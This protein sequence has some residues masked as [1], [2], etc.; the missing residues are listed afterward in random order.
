M[1][2]KSRVVVLGLT[3]LILSAVFVSHRH[4][5]DLVV[6]DAAPWS[7]PVASPGPS[8]PV[9][10][11][12]GDRKPVEPSI[13]APRT[14]LAP[15][16]VR[17]VDTQSR[18]VASAQVF[19]A[20][21][22]EE[23]ALGVSDAHG[24]LR[25]ENTVGTEIGDWLLAR[26]SG[27]GVGASCFDGSNNHT[28]VIRLGESVQL[29][30]RILQ[31]IEDLEGCASITV[32][33]IPRYLL[34]ATPKAGWP[35]LLRDSRVLLTTVAS[36]SSFVLDGAT[37]GTVYSLAAGGS[38]WI[39]DG[40]RIETPAPAN[41]IELDLHQL[42]ATRLIFERVDSAPF[43]PVIVAGQGWG[44]S[45]SL[46]APESSWCVADCVGLALAGISETELLEPSFEELLLATSMT[47]NTTHIAADASV[48]WLGYRAIES[49][50]ELTPVRTGLGTT[51]LRIEPLANEWGWIA[52]DLTASANSSTFVGGPGTLILRSSEDELIRLPVWDTTD[53][54]TRIGPIPTGSYA[55]GFE[56]RPSASEFPTTLDDHFSIQGD[57]DVTIRP[58]CAG[59][60]SLTI[61]VKDS[62][63]NPYV[64]PLGLSIGLRTS[65]ESGKKFSIRGDHVVFSSAPYHLGCLPRGPID[66]QGSFPLWIEPLRPTVMIENGGSSSIEAIVQ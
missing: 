47:P 56:W 27:Y 31:R 10:P 17:V 48:H 55:W 22:T 11:T 50:V 21:L 58:H 24:E 59:K 18:P 36:N 28:L 5:S 61:T 51:V 32:A 20:G 60:G 26:H 57:S 15:W 43:L 23:V 64:G 35:R 7:G 6:L 66:L 40:V 41:N 33:A 53:G 42:F 46:D 37:A 8:I 25:F 49:R 16:L 19:K 9:L 12:T 2:K 52:L 1:T 29:S 62:N 44:R 54:Y 38:G 63:G 34:L 39:Q 45:V 14:L 13:G 30:G 65:L 4:Q 3:I